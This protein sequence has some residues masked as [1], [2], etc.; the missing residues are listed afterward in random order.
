VPRER[1]ETTQNNLTELVS[2]KTSSESLTEI[3]RDMKG[4][5]NKTKT[6][7]KS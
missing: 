1:V 6:I 7:V 4:I 2:W 3:Y 5:M